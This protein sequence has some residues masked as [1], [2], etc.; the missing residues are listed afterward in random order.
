MKNITVASVIVFA[1]VGCGDSQNANTDMG[2][3]SQSKP[4]V[5][6]HAGAENVISL[7]DATRIAINGKVLRD[8]I[9]SVGGKKSQRYEINFPNRVMDSEG[10][11]FSVLAKSGYARKIISETPDSM[12]IHY[13]KKGFAVVGAQY[14]VVEF[15]HV[16]GDTGTRLSLYWQ[17]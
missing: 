6:V 13:Y 11:I 15:K 4:E 12:K 3:Q 16:S 8:E 17:L 5:Q 1:L 10:S 14:R 2:V 7:P 9:V